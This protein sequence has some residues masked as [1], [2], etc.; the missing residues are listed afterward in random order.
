VAALAVYGTIGAVVGTLGVVMGGI[1]ADRM[2]RRGRLDASLRV[3]LFAALAALVPGYFCLFA[4]TGQIAG[5]WLVPVMLFTSMPFGVAAAA[6]QQMVP[7]PIRGQASALFLFIVNLIGM[8][9]GPT[10]VALLTD[11]VFQ[12]DQSVHA[13]LAAVG[14]MAHLA[15]AL[16]LWQGLAPFRRT[17]SQVQ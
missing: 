13:A 3:G 8:G 9:I 7:S 11:Y 16:L 6:V 1:F 10:A 5:L 2:L 14:L 4:P 12:S 15:A 17:V